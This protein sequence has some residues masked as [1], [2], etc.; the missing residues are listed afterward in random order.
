MKRLITNISCLSGIFDKESSFLEMV[1]FAKNND[2]KIR[3]I[4]TPFEVSGLDKHFPSEKSWMGFT[5]FIS[6]FIGFLAAL[7]IILYIHY[8]PV[9]VFGDKPF[10][11]PAFLVPVV[12]QFTILFAVIGL[13]VFFLVK[14]HLHAGQV[15]KI[16]HIGSTSY[17][18]VIIIEKVDDLDKLMEGFKACEAIEVREEIFINQNYKLPF[19][20]KTID[21]GEIFN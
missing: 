1:D 15:N 8:N 17:L 3:G 18:F 14:N 21:N 13:L 6:G 2:Y 9:L 11:S 20:I 19:P 5:A 16:Y 7:A 10:L 4:Y 12:F